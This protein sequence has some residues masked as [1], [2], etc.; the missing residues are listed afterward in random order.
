MASKEQ[1]RFHGAMMLQL[2]KCLKAGK[3]DNSP[4]TTKALAY[5]RKLKGDAALRKNIADGLTGDFSIDTDIKYIDKALALAAKQESTVQVGDSSPDDSYPLV[6]DD[7]D[8][9]RAQY[10]K[11]ESSRIMRDTMEPEVVDDEEDLPY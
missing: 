3:I 1:I 5:A 10:T 4:D 7:L 2:R 6:E 11:E 8:A 9:I